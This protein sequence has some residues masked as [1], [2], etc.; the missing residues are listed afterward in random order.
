M[1]KKDLHLARLGRVGRCAWVFLPGLAVLLAGCPNGSSGAGARTSSPPAV[2]ACAA[3]NVANTPSR[4]VPRT[5]D[6]S[7]VNPTPPCTKVARYNIVE[8]AADGTPKQTTTSVSSDSTSATVSGL[9]LCTFYALGVQ[10]VGGSGQ[11]SQVTLPDH[12]V[13]ESGL[14]DSVPPVV[15]IVLQGIGSSIEQGSFDPA[16]VDYCTTLTGAMPPQNDQLPLQ[17]LASGWL[18][19]DRS[20]GN[21]TTGPSTVGAGSGNNLIDT[22]ASTGGYVL[23]FSYTGATVSGSGTS[24]TFTVNSYNKDD[25]ANNTI[26]DEQAKLDTEIANVR[27]V[28]PSAAIIVVGHSNGGLIAEQ[29]WLNHRSNLH[30][31]KQVFS[32]DSPLNGLYDAG[33]CSIHLCGPF[34]VGAKLGDFYSALWSSQDSNDPHWVSQDSQDKV[35]TAIGTYGD[36]LYDAGDNGATS[37]PTTDARI[38]IVSEL[39]FTEPDCAGN[40]P[41]PFDLSTS[42]CQPAGRYFIDPCSVVNGQVQ[43]HRGGPSAPLDGAWGPPGIPPGFGMPGSIW[44]HSVVKNCPGVIS[45]IRGYLPTSPA[46]KVAPKATVDCSAPGLAEGFSTLHYDVTGLSCAE[47]HHVVRSVLSVI[48]TTKVK[49]SPGAPWVEA[50]GFT[51][52]SPGLPVPGS[53][54]QLQPGALV[55]CTKGAKEVSF[56]L[57]G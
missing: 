30:G 32:L 48:G 3:H 1:N 50:D 19:Y 6:V 57:P 28:W 43:D 54:P 34:G 11:M 36:P 24:A 18:N 13:F 44:M 26:Q 39:F 27:N 17:A 2:S 4:S 38:G 10:A 14:P 8:I 35:F 31:V 20:K 22:L 45:Y 49:W 15:T 25:V 9:N 40:F 56:Q 55:M 33:L 21:V 47:G 12:P 37:L 5:M 42:R 7:W 41:D 46:P 53:S 51:C 52:Q 29:W 16:K 23:P